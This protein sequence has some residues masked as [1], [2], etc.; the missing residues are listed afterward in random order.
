VVNVKANKTERTS[1]KSTATALSLTG[2][3]RHRKGE[4]LQLTLPPHADRWLTVPRNLVAA[5]KR[6]SVLKLDDAE[7]QVATVTFGV[8]RGPKAKAL[9]NL[10]A[11][12]KDASSANLSHQLTEAG[13][14]ADR[15][16][17]PCWYDTNGIWHCR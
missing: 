13:V 11:A 10:L 2:L 14:D 9:F 16:A 12:Y 3:V 5:I 8:P 1:S 17:G 15:I 7:H 6:H 4:D